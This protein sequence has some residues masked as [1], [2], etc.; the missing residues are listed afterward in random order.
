MP[1]PAP[2]IDTRRYQDLVDELV[3]RIPVHTP[4]WTN[5]NPS[6]PGV[7]LIQLFAHVTESLLYRANQIPERNRAKFLSLLGVQLNPAREAR[8]LVAFANMHGP[9]GTTILPR[10]TELLAGT[11]PFRT[12]TSLDALPVEAKLYVK[13]P[14]AVVDPATREYYDLLYASYNRPMP[15]TLSLYES[16][17]AG[18]GD[19][20]DLGAS[21]DSA[22]WI[23]LLG[24]EGDRLAEPAARGDPWRGVREVLANRVLSLG[25]V[26]EQTIGARTLGPIAR[27]GAD[28]NVLRYHLPSV[29]VPIQRVNEAPAPGYRQLAPRADFDPVTSPGVV[30][31]TLPAASGIGTWQ[32]LDPL[33]AGVGDL[34]PAVDDARIADRIVTWLR[35]SAS[36]GSA[37]RFRWI[38]VNAAQVRQVIHVTSERLADGDG[39]PDQVRRLGRSPVLENSVS[40]LGYL[41]TTPREWARIDDILAADPEVP[42]Y[43][44]TVGD[45]PLTD[46]F[47]L[48]AE[49]G[50]I[51]FGDGL[52]G[53]RPRAGEVLYASYDYCEG[54]EGNVA[55]GSITAGPMVPSGISAR[56]PVPTWGGADAE[57]VAQGEKQVPRVIQHRER[58]V[59][60]DDFRT[61]AWRTPGVAI[62]RVEVLAA[63]HPDI[64]PVAPGTAPGVVTLMAIPRSDPLNPQAPRS[65]ARFIDALCAYL[66]PRRLVTTELV[67]RGADYVGIWVSL[68]IEIEANHNA[69]EVIA[70]VKAR[71]EQ[72]LSPLPAPGIA[73]PE[74][75]VPLYASETDP[76]LR[77]WPL[78]KP[79]NARSLLAEAARVAGVVS[80]ADV[81]LAGGGGPAVE[82]VSIAGLQ[83]PEIL[84]ISVVAGDPVPLDAV[85]GAGGA[86]DAGQGPPRLPV[87]VVA[88]TC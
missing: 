17:E 44:A 55:A 31:L 48:D 39:T 80:V 42:V 26:P 23:A 43:P 18:D 85:R 68:G 69:A 54:A 82:S 65:D 41:G 62:G 2:P 79:V 57:S 49:A 70:A 8:G 6:D 73:L 47:T 33:E 15:Q 22:V 21:V 3:Q 16:V 38:G 28:S 77:G 67:L 75:L 81:L 30:E 74:L 9:S 12:T 58:L 1:L 51:T 29:V 13:R 45:A 34:P 19:T 56:N 52:T 50:T 83:L 88:E 78:G 76:A 10:D 27:G 71:I 64:R 14:L 24:R 40:V 36:S 59:T 25:M 11:L 60:A 66:D 53:R 72:Y 20:I 84:G 37:P 63:S 87:P 7:T 35:I 61:I 32:D 5:F 46:V 86:S 4:E